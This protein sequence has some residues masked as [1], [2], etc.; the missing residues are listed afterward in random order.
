MR[1][2]EALRIINNYKLIK[3]NLEIPRQCGKEWLAM[4]IL[5]ANM[6]SYTKAQFVV[7][8]YRLDR[9]KNREGGR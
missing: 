7:R 4:E 8:R 1:Y 2:K 5:C 9:S 3:D 6:Y